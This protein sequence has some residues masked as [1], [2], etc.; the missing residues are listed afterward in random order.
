MKMT[1]VEFEP[2]ISESALQ[3][4]Y[5]LQTEQSSQPNQM[6]FD[7]RLFNQPNHHEIYEE[8]RLVVGW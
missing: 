3:S 6:I 7:K 1:R 8:Q 2:T 5:S 4:L